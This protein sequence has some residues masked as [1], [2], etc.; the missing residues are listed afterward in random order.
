MAKTPGPSVPAGSAVLLRMLL[1]GDWFGTVP[2]LVER[3]R[4]VKGFTSRRLVNL[5]YNSLTVNDPV[6]LRDLA[7][8]G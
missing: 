7:D 6:R 5:G 1:P 3:S 2:L 8:G 4:V